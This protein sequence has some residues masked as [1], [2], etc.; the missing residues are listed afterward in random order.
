MLAAMAP[1]SSPGRRRSANIVAL[2]ILALVIALAVR[3]H[4]GPLR[5]Y[6]A[7]V[8]R[9][10]LRSPRLE[11]PLPLT[12]VRPFG[13]G[14]GRPL[15]VLLAPSPEDPGEAVSSALFAALRSLGASAPALALPSGPAGAY[16]GADAGAWRSYL[17]SE[18]VPAAVAKLGADPRRV[19]LGGVGAG[20]PAAASIVRSDSRRFCAAGLA[21][22]RTS[23]STE[24][25]WREYLAAYAGALA[26]CRSG[27]STTQAS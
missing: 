14:S 6:G 23:P 17:L 19:A 2:V 22:V 27:A 20:G 4:G 15:L 13:A 5:T 9:V 10:V 8:R 12:L 24:P 25:A 26:S 11:G 18:A 7:A 3:A 16:A 21:R 1:S